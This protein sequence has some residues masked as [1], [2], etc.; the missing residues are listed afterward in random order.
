MYSFV[1]E[2]KNPVYPQQMFM[3]LYTLKQKYQAGSN[4]LC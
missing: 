2:K 4:K 3:L 1:E